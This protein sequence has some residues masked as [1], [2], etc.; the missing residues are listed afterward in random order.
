[1][2]EQQPPGSDL[3]DSLKPLPGGPAGEIMARA[4]RDLVLVVN[5]LGESQHIL[6]RHFQDF[7][8]TELEKRG[9]TF[10]DH[11]LL[12]PF[13]ETHGSE[14]AEFVVTGI[15]LH[16][17]FHLKDF[18]GMHGDP[19]GLLRLDI[20][21]TLQSYID[22]AEAHFISGMGGLQKIL[23]AVEE[24]RELRVDLPKDGA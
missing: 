5:F 18:E 22:Q 2:S 9:I 10:G 17:Q 4:E 20:G 1:M 7:V 24:A 12:L 13:I 11:P 23:A 14:L 6:Q 19:Q 21:N 3:P 16:H 8:R 15:G